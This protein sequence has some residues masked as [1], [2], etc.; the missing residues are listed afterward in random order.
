[1]KDI[2]VETIIRISLALIF[3]LFLG[4]T[5]IEKAVDNIDIF[6]I[7]EYLIDFEDDSGY[8]IKLDKPATRIIS[9]YPAHT[10]NLFS[11]GLNNE[12]IGVSSSDVY[13]VKVLDKKSYSYNSNPTRI[14]E[15][16]PDLVLIRPS[17]ETEKTNFVRILKRAGINVVSLYPNKFEEYD[18]YIIKIGMLTGRKNTA[19]KL[20]KKFH[21]DIKQIESQATYIK[22]KVGV[23]FESSDVGYKT[24]T[25]D[26]VMIKAIELAGGINVAS[27]ACPIEKELP[28]AHYGINKILYKREKID[29]YLSL[30][31][32]RGAGGNHHSIM[33]R[34]KFK[35]IS[36]IE[37]D[38]VY[39]INY[40][41]VEP[42]FKYIRGIK[43]LRRIFY[44]EVFDDISMYNS[45]EIIT[46]E[47]A[48]EIYVKKAHKRIFVPSSRYF[49]EEHEDHT[50]G[51]F[52]DVSE[53]HP[54]FDFIE[55][56]VHLGYI[57]G[58]EEDGV[59]YFY[60]QKGISRDE[61]AEAIFLIS[62][63]E[64]K[65]KHI[66]IKDIKQIDNKKIVQILVDNNIFKLEEGYFKPDKL[67][68]GE[69]AVSTLNKINGD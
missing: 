7:G 32:K 26:S 53:N 36:A 38:K 47:E 19:N 17:F 25:K 13:P 59:E 1:M 3:I 10:Q 35:D 46:R 30:R 43:E 20:L 37:N 34:S 8:R 24:F 29:I 65:E 14:I 6:H 45:E 63:F 64:V 68:T 42:T 55:T 51:F 67:V 5:S 15:A 28:R 61:F 40:N 41:L 50:Y 11:L 52:E 49:R 12:I 27:N 33:A 44:P 48:A 21:N 58:Y 62:D 9:L 16:R 57:D 39:E 60:P 22:D 56:A 23:Y 31:G 2:K 66:E 69:E 18:D 4:R 54:R